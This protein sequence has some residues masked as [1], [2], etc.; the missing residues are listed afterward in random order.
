MNQINNNLLRTIFVL[1]MHVYSVLSILIDKLTIAKNYI[2]VY[3]PQVTSYFGE[4]VKAYV[5]NVV[6]GYYTHSVVWL[7]LMSG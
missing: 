7:C 4:N 3:I 6:G 5:Y 1:L 2:C